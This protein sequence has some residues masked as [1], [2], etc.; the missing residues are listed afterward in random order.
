[1]NEQPRPDANGDERAY[2]LTVED[3][4]V[5][6]EKA[7]FARTRRAIQKYCARGDLDCISEQ[8]EYGER[9]RITP[10][11]VA[12]HIEQI[13]QLSQANGREQPRPDA[14]IRPEEHGV[15]GSGERPRTEANDIFEHPYV[16]RLEA[17]VGRLNDKYEKQVRRTEEVML[18]ANARLIEL[19]QANAIAQSETLAKY[20]LQLRAGSTPSSDLDQPSDAGG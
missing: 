7:G 15:T 4:A 8:T 19:Q 5:L 6:Y 11:S 2:T 12:R 3:A 16:K 20:M 13:E 14:N 17:E 9:F 1:M 18:D 10:L